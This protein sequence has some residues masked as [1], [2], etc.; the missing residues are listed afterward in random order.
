MQGAA[1]WYMDP[2]DIRTIKEIGR[3]SFGIVRSA[4][5]HHTPVAV[6]ILY[7]DAQAE[8]RELFE[9]EVLLMATLH[10][11]NI[12]QFFGFTRTPEL[13]LVIEYF[14]EGSLEQFV[15][16]QK[17]SAKLSLSFCIDMALA[18]EYLHSRK[19]SI[20]I[21]RDL[22]PQ[23]FLLTGSHRVKL[24][25]FGIARAR[26]YI[27]HNNEY[28]R[29]NCSLDTLDFVPS[30]INGNE[31]RGGSDSPCIA[32]EEDL[33]SNCGTARF[34]APEI[35]AADGSRTRRYSIKAD[36]YSLALVYYF[37]WERILPSIE[38][39]NTPP[40]HL[41]AI[42][43]GKRPNFY[44]TPKLMRDI[45]SDMWQLNPEARPKASRLLDYLTSLRAKSSP[46]SSANNLI[47][48]KKPP[49]PTHNSP[50]PEKKSQH[51]PSPSA[52]EAAFIFGRRQTVGA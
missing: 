24:G 49:F 43:S 45:I 8:D 17:P 4:E 37:V 27:Q 36:I 47:M 42:I 23:N 39:H 30:S 29:S 32:T 20:V 15:L 9:R 16:N 50:P 3:G 31:E 25:D 48:I 28:S 44:R 35:A 10:H 13:T 33:T 51:N 34:M 41:E 26:K 52:Q 5:W 14:P 2:K 38:K 11:P 19:P 21:H 22:K 46:L 7:Q 6:K 40:L 12:V 1:H 18:I